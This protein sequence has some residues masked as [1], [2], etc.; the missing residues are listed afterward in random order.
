MEFEILMYSFK[1]YVDLLV[2]P[3]ECPSF[4]QSKPEL[5]S[6]VAKS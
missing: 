1:S 6:E 3:A 4:W 5:K 2:L